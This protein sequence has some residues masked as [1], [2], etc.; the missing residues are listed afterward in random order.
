MKTQSNLLRLGRVALFFLV[1]GASATFSLACDQPVRPASAAPPD[2]HRAV[3]EVSVDGPER[4]DGVLN[5]VENLRKAFGPDK[6]TVEVVAHGKG[7]GFLLATNEADKSRIDAL[8]K[9]GVTF[10]ACE[11]T[12]RKMNVTKEQLL[13]GIVTVD[14]GVAEVVRKQEASFAYLK[15]GG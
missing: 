13:P 15:S 1:A 10:A 6:T 14:S 4:W 7:L 8:V 5:N 3:F 2:T 11:N 9:G 12:M